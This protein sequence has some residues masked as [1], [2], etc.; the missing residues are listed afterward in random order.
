MRAYD[1]KK[2]DELDVAPNGFDCLSRWFTMTSKRDP[3]LLSE[4]QRNGLLNERKGRTDKRG[5]L[6]R[7][8]DVESAAGVTSDMLTNTY[9]YLLIDDLA[10]LRAARAMR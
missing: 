10:F 8:S 7:V 9:S 4:Q 2:K 1:E 3:S 5:G 6:T